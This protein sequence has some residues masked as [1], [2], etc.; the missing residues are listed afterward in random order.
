M[1]VVEPTPLILTYDVSKIDP[2]FVLLLANENP[3]LMSVFV[4]DGARLND[5]SPYVFVIEARVITGVIFDTTRVAVIF[6][7][8]CSCVAACVAVMIVSPTL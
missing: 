3:P 4:D 1:I 7:S 5:I 8:A 6:N 2:T